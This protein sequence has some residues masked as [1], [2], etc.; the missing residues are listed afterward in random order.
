MESAME[1]NTPKKRAFKD[2]LKSDYRN[3]YTS[4]TE[5]WW[6]YHHEYNSLLDRELKEI[7]REID[8]QVS[9]RNGG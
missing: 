9:Q 5:N 8:E 1:F 7:R 2:Y 4:G 3:P 6:E